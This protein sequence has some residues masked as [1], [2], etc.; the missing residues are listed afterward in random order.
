MVAAMLLVA[1]N[2]K[3]VTR[4][5]GAEVLSM[6]LLCLTSSYGLVIAGMFAANWVVR[7]VRQEHSL[8][9]TGNGSPRCWR[10]S[11]RRWSY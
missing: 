5:R 4:N 8:I 2:W 7:F 9:R 1:I 10:C 11:R 3:T 6:M